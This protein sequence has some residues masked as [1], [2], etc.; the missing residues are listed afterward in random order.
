M[1]NNGMIE[2]RCKK[3]NKHFMDYMIQFDDTAVVMQSINI[4]CDRCKKVI[5]LKR[6]TE[7]FLISHSKKGSFKI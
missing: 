1:N 2:L 5:V 7:G 4:K 3:C 6:Y